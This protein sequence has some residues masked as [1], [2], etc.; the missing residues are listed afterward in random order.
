M[1]EED[2]KTGWIWK[3]SKEQIISELQ[4]R[5]VTLNTNEKR[6][7]LRALLVRTVRES[8]EN[9]ELKRILSTPTTSQTNKSENIRDNRK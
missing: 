9:L 5:G 8:K 1:N 6:D 7:N 4:V 3:F 2:T